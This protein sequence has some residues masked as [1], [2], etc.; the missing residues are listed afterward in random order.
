M[1]KKK[2]EIEPI[3]SAK[4]RQLTLAKRKKGLMK[5]AMEL[6]ILC[7][8]DIFLSVS[9]EESPNETFFFSSKEIK[10][11]NKI[12]GQTIKKDKNAIYFKDD[13][14][15]LFQKKSKFPVQVPR[16]KEPQNDY[17]N[18]TKSDG[19]EDDIENINKNEIEENILNYMSSFSSTYSDLSNP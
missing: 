16:K 10:V 5:K 3:E 18:Q 14:K 8:A 13:Y 9:S 6:S 15:K 7:N 2:I 17:D 12:I 4:T 19:V 11:M 1:G